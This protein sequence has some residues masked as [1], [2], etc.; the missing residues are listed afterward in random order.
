MIIPIK[1]INFELV[2]T[3]TNS[4]TMIKKYIFCLLALCCMGSI[5]AQTL[6]QAKKMFDNGEYDPIS[7]QME[8]FILRG[9]VYGN[10][11]NYIVVQQQKRR[12]R[13]I[14]VRSARQ[15]LGLQQRSQH[16]SSC[17]HRN[18]TRMERQYVV[19]TLRRRLR[20][21]SFLP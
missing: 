4:E 1:Y 5:S 12:H 2:Y 13:N 11:E 3:L 20:A 18:K 7:K 19:Q 14:I 10:V 8:E 17:W 21:A 16:Q 15:L 6:N 9:G